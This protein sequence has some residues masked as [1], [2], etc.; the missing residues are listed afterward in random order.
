LAAFPPFNL[1]LLVFAALIPWL[2]SLQPESCRGFRSGYVFGFVFLGGQFTFIFTLAE[3]WTGNVG[4]SLIPWMLASLLGAC[5]FGLLGWLAKICWRRDVPWAI[6]L[7]WAG[8]EVFRSYFPALAFPFGLLATPLWLFTPFIQSGWFLTIFGV[9]AWIVW[10]NITV[11][12]FLM[13]E[14]LLR[15]RGALAMI[16]AVVVLSLLRFS[17]PVEGTLKAVAAG[18]PGFDMAFDDPND[19]DK[20]RTNLDFIIAKASQWDV[21][22]LVLP[23]G[24]VKAGASWPEPP[25]QLQASVPTIFGGQR[26]TGPM[27]Q[28][29]FGFDGT[30]QV[31]DKTRL[32]VFGEYV[33]FRD[34]LPFLNS[35][36]LP[37]GDLQPGKSIA[38]LSFEEMKVAPLICFEALFPDIALRQGQSGAQLVSVLSIDDWF[39]GSGA[40]EQLRAASIWRAVETGLP[41]VRS[42]SQGVTLIADGKGQVLAELPFGVNDAIRAEVK[43]QGGVGVFLGWWIFPTLAVLSLVAVP[44][45]DLARQRNSSQNGE[46]K[47]D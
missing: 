20:Y 39:V 9:G 22:L 31:V 46:K 6:P 10:V 44:I 29:A 1:S 11:G 38:T 41:V 2:M 21:D 12:R 30:W 34:Q 43:V 36:R 37:A 18:Q 33:P 25:F 45:W 15:L 24:L 4:L 26:G 28:S 47:P 16:G 3:R 8:I 23:E 40:V 32:V 13:G 17:V 14:P 7:V 5:Y 19:A 42:A 27:Y 35:F